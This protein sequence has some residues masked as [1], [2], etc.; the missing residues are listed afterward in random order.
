MIVSLQDISFAY[1]S[2]IS[3]IESMNLQ[4]E[5]GE[6]VGLIG[7]NGAGKSTLLKLLVGLL[8]V[9]S[10]EV[11]ILDLPVNQANL[12]IIRK[13]A[14]FVFQ[15]AENQLFMPTVYEDLAFGPYNYGLRDESLEYRV[16]EVLKELGIEKLSNRKTSRLSGGEKKL[17]SIGTVLALEPS[18]LIFDE[19]SI[20]LDPGNRRRLIEVLKA[21]TIGKLIATHDL[22]LV[23]DVCER[24]ILLKEGVILADGPAKEILR[25]EELLTSAG[26]EL[27]LCLQKREEY[28][29]KNTNQQKR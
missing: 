2:N 27:P 19:P 20:A 11:K 6:S 16:K 9:D 21:L 17:V 8:E 3:I 7:A 24:V 10:G 4:I 18:L 23:L 5:E 13:Q 25:D 14:G 22:D 29:W 12:P 28:G 26:L 1:E 15:D